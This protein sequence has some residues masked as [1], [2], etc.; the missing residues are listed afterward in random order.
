[1]GLAPREGVRV[2]ALVWIYPVPMRWRVLVRAGLLL[3]VVCAFATVD[4]LVKGHHGGMRNAVGN[5]SA[6]WALL[7]LLSGAFVKPRRLG[8]GALVGMASTL[9][10]LVCYSVVRAV[11]FGG[12]PQHRDAG[13]VVIAAA[14]NRWFLLGAVGGALLGAAGA[15]LAVRRQ[16]AV[17]VAIAA[18]FLVLEPAARILWAVTKGEPARTL[19]PGPVVWLGEVCCGVA[20]VIGSRLRGDRIANRLRRSR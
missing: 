12:G 15:R 16:W 9:A 17:L 10:A 3:I 8:F 14:T 6:P 18:A 20:I 19:V 1:M 11:A 13:S 4:A 7:P 5:V 2:P